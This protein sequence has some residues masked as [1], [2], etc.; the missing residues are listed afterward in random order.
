MAIHLPIG[1]LKTRDTNLVPTSPLAN[2]LATA[3]S[4]P[5]SEHS[6]EKLTSLFLRLLVYCCLPVANRDK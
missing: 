6:S 1:P 3:P 4:G 2:D 5:L